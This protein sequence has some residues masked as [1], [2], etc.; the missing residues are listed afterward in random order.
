MNINIKKCAAA[1]LAT[2][3]ALCA[4]AQNTQSGY[5]L[6]DYAYRFL[7]NPALAPSHGKLLVGIPGINNLNVNMRGNLALTDVIY[8]V[9]GKTTTFM[10]PGVS[11]AEAMGNLSNMNRIG[12]DIREN[13]LSFGF[14]M[15]G[16][17]STINISARAN[18]NVRLPKSIFSF[19]KEGVSNN[20]YEIDG[21]KARALGYAEISLGHSR[22]ITDE[23]RVGANIKALLGVGSLKADL[24]RA[25]LALNRDSWDIITNANIHTSLKGYTYETKYS[26]DTKREYVSGLDGSFK[27]INGFGMALD[28]GATYAPKALKDWEFSAAIL[29]IGF[30]KWEN[31][32]YATTNGERRFQ[33]SIYNF[34]ADDNANNSFSNEWDR[35]RNSLEELYQLDDAGDVGGYTQALNAT[36]NIGASYTLPVYRRLKFGLL[37]TTRIAG[38]FSWTDFRLSANINPVKNISLAV[39]GNAGTL[40]AGFGW[41]ANLRIPYAGIQLYLAQDNFF[42]KL[43][44]PGVPMSSNASISLGLNII[45]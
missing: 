36:V 42:A 7:S 13:I 19:L 31:D 34:S 38:D 11:A 5:F 29:D 37:N 4:T 16:G 20:T 18:V 26:E 22:K 3:A 8:N 41:M 2:A 33:S 25:T 40:G 35:M 14:G 28:L 39:N 12:F 30:M 17:Y 43:A 27:P 1:M 9:N 15:L 10:N 44:K 6:D 45:L 32:L 21:L 23:I 24:D